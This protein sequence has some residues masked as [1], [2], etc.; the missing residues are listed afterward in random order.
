MGTKTLV[1]EGLNNITS[2][3]GERVQVTPPNAGGQP[4]EQP[5]CD[6]ET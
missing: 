1:P 5:N 3:K 2:T 6:Q 4:F